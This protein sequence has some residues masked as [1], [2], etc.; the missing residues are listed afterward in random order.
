[1][2]SEKKKHNNENFQKIHKKIP[3]AESF[4]SEVTGLNPVGSLNY[5]SGSGVF[6]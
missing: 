6:L 3:V 1:M 4:C 5:D 2:C